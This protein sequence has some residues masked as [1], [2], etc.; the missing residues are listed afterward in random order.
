MMR[1]TWRGWVALAVALLAGS[2]LADVV[3]ACLK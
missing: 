3:R 1:L 2:L